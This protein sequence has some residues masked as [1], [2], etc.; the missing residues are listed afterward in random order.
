MTLYYIY[1]DPATKQYEIYQTREAGLI[2]TYDVVDGE[3]VYYFACFS[4]LIDASRYIQR[5]N[6]R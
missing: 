6:A 5:E 3:R 2:G 1:H 4:R